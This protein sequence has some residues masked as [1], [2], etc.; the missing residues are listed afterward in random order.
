MR[1]GPRRAR[2][3]RAARARARAT[4]G[5]MRCARSSASS[6]AWLGECGGVRH[7][8][9]WSSRLR[10]RSLGR[11]PRRLVLLWRVREDAAVHVVVAIS[12]SAY[13]CAGGRRW[14]A[15][16]PRARSTSPTIASPRLEAAQVVEH[17]FAPRSRLRH[18]RDVR[19]ELDARVAPERV[20]RRQRLGIGHVEH[21]IGRSVRVRAR[22]AGPH[23]TSCGPRP[24]CTRPA[25]RGSCANSARIR[26]SR[27]CE[28]VSGSRHTRMSVRA[29]K[30]RAVRRRRRGSA[31]RRSSCRERLHPAQS[32]P[33]ADELRQHRLPQ[34]AQAEHADA[35][36]AAGRTGRGRHWPLLLLRAGRR[37]MSRCRPSTACVTYSTMPCTMPGSTMRTTG[38]SGGSA[39][40]S[41]W[42][43]PAPEENSTCEI[44]EPRCQIGRRLPR[45]EEA[46]L[47]RIADVGPDAEVDVWRFAP[48]HLGPLPASHRVGLVDEDVPI[49]HQPS[50]CVTMA[51]SRVRQAAQPAARRAPSSSAHP[52][53][54]GPGFRP[55]PPGRCRSRFDAR[56][57]AG[58]QAARCAISALAPSAFGATTGPIAWPRPKRR[59][60]AK[61]RARAVVVEHHAWHRASRKQFVDQRHRAAC[62]V[63]RRRAP[64]APAASCSR[65]GAQPPPGRSAISGAGCA[66]PWCCRIRRCARTPGVRTGRG[67][68]WWH[69]AA[70]CSRPGLPAARSSADGRCAGPG[71]P[72]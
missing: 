6:A 58:V 42:S 39:A 10:C 48:E 19:R 54:A 15:Q 66:T 49:A 68:R 69:A 4:T 34:R 47:R 44:R 32:K 28:S 7:G 45:R 25:P 18:A 36:L 71:R 65:C 40:K 5:W 21:G 70:R 35:P 46:H 2:W 53:A 12:R 31:R 50:A 33:Q 1:R 13:S 61:P 56:E 59:S 72:A 51:N 63:P 16:Y 29:R 14:H 20:L 8:V 9:R 23:S 55:I 22:R 24:T 26:E 64:A 27:A 11:A 41:N 67:L 30:R 60:I 43:T 3:R 37:G 57:S 38:S 52:R 17:H 62:R